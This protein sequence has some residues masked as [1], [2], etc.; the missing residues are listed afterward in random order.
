MTSRLSTTVVITLLFVTPELFDTETRA[1]AAVTNQANVFSSS[2]APLTRSTGG[3]LESTSKDRIVT[4]SQADD[5]NSTADNVGTSVLRAA[6][7]IGDTD[8]DGSTAGNLYVPMSVG[9]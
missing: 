9:N 6:E 7:Q 8:D 2:P 1:E 5:Q 4:S 3:A